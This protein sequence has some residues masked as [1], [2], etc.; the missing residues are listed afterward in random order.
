MQAR[1][2]FSRHPAPSDANKLVLVGEGDQLILQHAGSRIALEPAGR[3]N[4]L[5]KHPDFE[6]FTLRFGREKEVVTEAFN[7]SSW[8]TN[9]RY[10]GP[11]NLSTQRDG[12]PLRVIFIRTVP[13]MAAYG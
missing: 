10:S 5:V 6:L 7:G 4:F 9:E 8:W 11:K 2:R 12:M 13:G 3:D 1:L